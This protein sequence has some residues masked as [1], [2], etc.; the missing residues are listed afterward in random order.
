ML[1]FPRLSSGSTRTWAWAIVGAVVVLACLSPATRVSAEVAPTGCTKTLGGTLRGEDGRYLSAFVGAVFYD[2]SR[3]PIA[4]AACSNPKPGYDGTNSVN[5]N[6]TCCY[7][8]GPDGASSGE[9]TWSI[10]APGNAA[11]AW[12]EAYPKASTT[13]DGP[14]KT[15]YER[16]G[17]AMR[18]MVP[19]SGG[20]ALRL[21]L[22]C[23]LGAGGDNG[24]IK[25]RIVKKGVP[26][27]VTRVAAFSRA[28]DGPSLI[29]GF[30][31]QGQPG[32]ADGRFGYVQ[33]SPGQRYALNITTSAGSFWFEHDYGKGIPVS[34]CGTT[35]V[36]IDVGYSP[37]RLTP[38]PGATT[39]GVRRD[40]RML[41][42]NSASGG[43]PT[44][45]FVFGL[46]NDRILVGDWNGDGIDTLGVQ[47]DRTFLLT[48]ATDGA[49]PFT[50]VTYGL[51]TDT[52]VVGDWDGNGTDTIG[53]RRGNAYYLRNTNTS[54]PAHVSFGYGT[55]TDTPVVGDWDGNGTDTPGIRRGNA[56]YLRNTNTSGPAHLSFGYG[57]ATDTPVVGDW[58]GNG[59]DTPGVRRDN[60]FHLRN[61][62]TSGPAHLS[63]GY[64]TA[65]DTPV[66]GD[67]DGG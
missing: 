52:P 45:D 19:V 10:P 17:G 46:T 55:A 51:A 65:T 3:R 48:N 27:R 38:L 56:Y 18:R 50:S 60:V 14:H 9:E 26:V 67:W 1:A 4:A 57:T 37:P 24:A 36:S 7:L 35:S 33:L 20:I 13:P 63:L 49:G 6:G 12:I 39:V 43:V 41:L 29:M 64:G 15:T 58:D 40:T 5:E 59:T 31:V 23:G 44:A 32:T 53:V 47:R 25:G 21:P 61:T 11:Y 22:G 16:Y 34:A 42:T 30:G 62:N 8:L 66:V 28:T 54:G 2:S